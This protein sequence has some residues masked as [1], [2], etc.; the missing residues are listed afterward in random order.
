MSFLSFGYIFGLYSSLKLSIFSFLLM[1][2]AHR[3]QLHYG[4]KFYVELIVS[5]RNFDP[6]RAMY[7]GLLR[8]CGAAVLTFLPVDLQDPLELISEFVQLWQNGY[9]I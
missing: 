8:S 2:V 6:F 9:E 3:K 4:F 7:N 5:S 1:Y